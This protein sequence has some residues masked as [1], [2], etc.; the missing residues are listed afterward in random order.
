MAMQTE[1]GRHS[2]PQEARVLPKRRLLAAQ[3]WNPMEL[4]GESDCSTSLRG[5]STGDAPACQPPVCTNSAENTLPG[6]KKDFCQ[7]GGKVN[8]VEHGRLPGWWVAYL[9]SVSVRRPDKHSTG[10][11]FYSLMEC[12][13]SIFVFGIWDSPGYTQQAHKFTVR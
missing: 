12:R 1:Q 4:S 11:N 10:T 9:P 8:G 3:L 6:S 7:L 2:L 13:G 5:K